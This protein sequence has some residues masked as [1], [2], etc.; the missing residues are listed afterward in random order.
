MNKHFLR[1]AFFL[2]ICLTLLLSVT[3]RVVDIPDPNLRAAVENALGKVPGTTITVADMATLTVLNASE[4]NITDLTGLEHAT[5]LTVLEL[6]GNNISEL[7]PLVANTGLGSG[8]QIWLNDNPLSYSSIKTHIPTLQSQGVT[9]EF[10]DTTHLNVGEPRTVRIIYFLPSDSESQPDIDTELDALIKGAQQHYVEV[11][12]SHGFGRKTFSFETDV[13]GKAMVHHIDGRFADAYYIHNTTEKV[14]EEIDEQFDTSKN[15]YLIAIKI[16]NYG[17]DNRT[18]CSTGNFNGAVGGFALIPTSGPYFNIFVTAHE[19][20]HAFG[21]TH[22]YRTSDA[23]TTSFFA[24]EWLDAHR[25]FNARLQ[26]QNV[27]KT[28]VQMLLPSLVSEPNTIRLR[29]E[30]TDLEGLHQA[31]LLTPE[32]T[33]S[34]GLIACKRLAGTSSTVEFVTSELTTKS[35]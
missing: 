23:M 2:L 26:E 9:V 3:A 15:I 22:D 20:G 32:V 7:S 29:F 30:V 13:H 5:N 16:S 27:S 17:L 18:A 34:G 6:G 14:L 28:M 12:E 1:F 31:Q 19:L 10:D 8:Y 11:I 35:N 21:L 4:A 25:Y 24:A 33:Y